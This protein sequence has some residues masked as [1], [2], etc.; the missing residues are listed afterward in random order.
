[1]TEF[2]TEI[3]NFEAGYQVCQRYSFLE[4]DAM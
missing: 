1:M 3:R 4:C 2:H